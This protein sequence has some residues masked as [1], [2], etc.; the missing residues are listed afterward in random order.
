M[1][2]LVCPNP[3]VDRTLLFETLKKEIPNRPSEVREFPGGKSFNVA[4]SL[5]F[6]SKEPIMI[7]TMLG[8]EY[9]RRVESLAAA[10]DYQLQTTPVH[11]NTRLCNILVDK[12]NAFIV[13]IYE[14]GFDLAAETLTNFTDTLVNAIHNGD[15][16]VFSGSLMQGMPADYISQVSEKLNVRSI[17]YSLCV[18][19]GGEALVSTYQTTKPTM[20]K[21]N[22]EEILDLF[23]GKSLTNVDDFLDLLKHEINPEIPFFIITL[24]KAGVIARANGHYYYG[25]AKPIDAKNPIASGDFFLGRVLKGLRSKTAFAKTLQDALL[26]STCNVLNWYPE[27]T[28]AQLIEIAPTVTVK[29][30]TDK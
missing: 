15:F 1:I 8:G 3:A 16:L 6:D 28:S 20:I 29:Q 25:Y 30:L 4:Y 18:D 13:P 26:F 21:I 10:R 27:I 7:H 22:D 5:T 24:G 2:H 23:P 14:K 17:S 19:T 12:T 9:G 11:D